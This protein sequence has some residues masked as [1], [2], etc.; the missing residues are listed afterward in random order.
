MV[1]PTD[2]IPAYMNTE[3]WI[4]YAVASSGVKC[5]TK[6]LLDPSGFLQDRAYYE[7]R[8]R[9]GAANR[10]ASGPKVMQNVRNVGDTTFPFAGWGWGGSGGVW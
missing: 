4:E 6:L 8:V 1:N 7:E 9:S 5:Y 2:L 3:D 10:Q